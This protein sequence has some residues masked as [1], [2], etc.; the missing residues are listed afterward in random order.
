MKPT[1]PVALQRYDAACRA[2][3]AARSTDEVMKIRNA[4]IAM[5]AYARQAKNRQLEQDAIA[6]RMRAERRVGELMAAQRETVGLRAGARDAKKRKTLRGTVTDLRKDVPT[7][8][9]AGIDKHLAD[10]ARKM[11]AIPVDRFDAHVESVRQNIHASSE[12]PEHY[13]PKNLL[14]RVIAVLDEIDLDPCSNSATTPNVPAL[15]QYTRADNGLQ[16]PWHGRVFMNPPY[17]REIDAWIEKLVTE[18][19]CGNVT[20]AIALVP[21]RTDTRWFG[22]LRDYVC[23]FIAGRLVFIGNEDPAPFPS[24]VFYLG[25]ELGK[26][27]YHFSGLGDIWQRIEP[28]MF[29]D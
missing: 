13:T 12:T 9:D 19:E 8:A 7:L 22:R 10:R 4:A 15:V 27:Y 24:A 20:E 6:V 21:A 1:E 3:A 17:G 29:A 23:C 2:I 16:Q 26:F 5:K 11:A 25:D 28:G 18:V 14:E